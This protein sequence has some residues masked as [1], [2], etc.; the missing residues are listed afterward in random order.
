MTP[1]AFAPLCDR[2]VAFSGD[3]VRNIKGIR[4]SQDL[5]DDLSPRPDDWAV[6][7]ALEGETGTPGPAAVITRPFDYGT[8]I[9]YSFDPAH[10]NAT[11]F[12]DG[13]RYGVWYG[14]TDLE[15]TVCETVYHWHRFLMD[16]FG[17]EDR[18]ITGERR[19]CDVHCEAILTDLRGRET[20]SPE[21]VSRSSYVFTQRL[22]AYLRDEG[23]AGLMVRSA[24]C[25]GTNAAVFSPTV[26][27]NVRDRCF[28]T[29]R[30]NPM[31]DSVTVERAT[32][33]RLMEI[34]PSALC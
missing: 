7:M 34:L 28:L 8:L 32:G 11:R 30:C 16:S 14:S 22:G 33:R 2:T 31:H 5:F 27:S 9:A 19:V 23:S 13:R 20:S 1:S 29:Y 24:R 4:T 21:L 18:L 25:D 17:G 26:L 12:S 3:L 10:W 15:T 6:A